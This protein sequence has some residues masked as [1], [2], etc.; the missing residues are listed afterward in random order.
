MAIRKKTSRKVTIDLEDLPAFFEEYQKSQNLDSKTEAANESEIGPMIEPVPQTFTTSENLSPE[1]II[2]HGGR[3]LLSAFMIG[4]VLILAGVA[5]TE[6]LNHSGS[7]KPVP[8]GATTLVALPAIKYSKG[9]IRAIDEFGGKFTPSSDPKANLQG[10]IAPLPNPISN[11]APSTATA[12]S[13]STTLPKVTIV[14]PKP[15]VPTVSPK[16]VV[17][18]KPVVPTVSPKPVVPVKPVVPTVSPKKI[19]PRKLT[20]PHVAQKKSTQTSSTSGTD[21]QATAKTEPQKKKEHYYISDFFHRTYHRVADTVSRAGS[22]IWGLLG[23]GAVAIGFL[24]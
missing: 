16:P 17:P 8:I 7:G 13:I 3:A 2:E 24:W 21:Q 4:A 6:V 15:V 20:S 14:S 1:R 5:V 22:S 9:E 12:S 11:T 19:S 23:A 18:V 10:A